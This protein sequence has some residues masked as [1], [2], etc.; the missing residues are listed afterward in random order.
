LRNVP[1]RT[2][3]LSTIGIG[4]QNTAMGIPPDLTHRG[5]AFAIPRQRLSMAVKLENRGLGQT[6]RISDGESIGLT[7]A[8]SERSDA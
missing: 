4:Y 6:I 8:R 5:E 1:D 2:I 7:G 3:D